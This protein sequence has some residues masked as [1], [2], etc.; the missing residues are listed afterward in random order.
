MVGVNKQGFGPLQVGPGASQWHME[1]FSYGTVLRF[2]I[3]DAIYYDASALRLEPEVF[4]SEIG[5]MPLRTPLQLID[6]RT[7]S[8]YHGTDLGKKIFSLY[9][10]HFI[11][12][13]KSFFDQKNLI[14]VEG[15]RSFVGTHNDL[16]EQAASVE[17]VRVHARNAYRNFDGVR[18]STLQLAKMHSKN[19]VRILTAAGSTGNVLVFDMHNLGYTGINIGNA[20][21]VYDFAL[22]VS[23][24]KTWREIDDAKAIE[25]EP[26]SIGA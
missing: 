13:L 12:R 5:L 3:P 1:H 15:E 16:F 10:A 23:G 19:N 22:G 8:F 21:L 20:S 24:L 7:P 11:S 25:R 14:V 17:R 2:V 4:L 26:N 6:H 9:Q 18:E